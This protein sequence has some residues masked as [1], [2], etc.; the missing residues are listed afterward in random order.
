MVLDY[1]CRPIL[2]WVQSRTNTLTVFSL[3]TVEIS[4]WNQAA[5]LLK[6]QGTRRMSK[7]NAN[8]IKDIKD[9]DPNN[10]SKSIKALC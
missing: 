2:P 6:N 9:S 4:S 10:L 8:K 1:P 3:S 5:H 7:V